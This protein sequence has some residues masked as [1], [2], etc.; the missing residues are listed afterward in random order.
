MKAANSGLIPAD[1]KKKKKTEAF[2]IWESPP[3]QYV[4]FIFII[5]TNNPSS[6]INRGLYMKNFETI[7]LFSVSLLGVVFK[8]QDDYLILIIST[9]TRS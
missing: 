6:I 4:T 8:S 7:I 5:L 9:T 3:I 2:Q 1:C